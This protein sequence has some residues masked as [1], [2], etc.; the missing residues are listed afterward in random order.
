MNRERWE[1]VEQI[2]HEAIQQSPAD[3]AA[4]VAERCAGDDALLQE[5]ESLVAANAQ[6]GVFL[7]TPAMQVAASALSRAAITVGAGQMLGP[8]QLLMPVGAGG[9]GEVW[10]AHD[11]RVGRDVAIKFCKSF[12]DHFEREARSIG[13]LNHPNICGLYDVGP[14]YLV[15][16]LVEGPT[17]AD[18]IQQGPIPV[19][20]ALSIGRQIA[21]ALEA[22]HEKGRIHRDLKPGNIKISP[23]GVVKLLDFGL[24]KAV[25]FPAAEASQSA[26]VTLSAVRARAIMG[27]PAY[28]SPEHVRGSP[29]DKR[30]DIWAFGAVLY[31]MLTGKP[32]FA[33]ETA[34]QILEAVS[35]AEPDWSALPASTQARIRKLLRRCLERD[36]KQRLRDIGEA[37]I[38]IDEPEEEP[39]RPTLPV[40]PWL[41]AAALALGLAVAAVGWWHAAQ[42]V[43]LRPLMRV[44]VE[45]GSEIPLAKAGIQGAFAIAPDGSR[46]AFV[47]R[48][49][50]G[51]ERLATRSFNESRSTLLAGT[52]NAEGPFFSPDSNWMGF[53]AD[54]KLKKISVH[55]GAPVTLC[56]APGPRGASWGEDGNIIAAL[57][58]GRPGLTRIPSAGGPPTPVK[59]VNAPDEKTNRWP[60][61]LSGSHA[62]LFNAYQVGDNPDDAEIQV[63]SFKTGE[64]KTVEHGYF[65]R[66]IRSGH[67]VFLR[68]NTLFAAP[69]DLSRL[70]VAGP[71][72][73]V[74][75]DVSAPAFSGA[76]NLDFSQTGSF[77][78]LAGAAANRAIFWLDSA[79]N[80]RPLHAERGQ[81]YHPAFSPDGKRLAFTVA[82]GHGMDIWVQDFA[83]GDASRK[84]FLPGR[85]WWPLWTPNGKAIVFASTGGEVR[86]TLYMIRADG[87][88]EVERI[89]DENVRGVPRSFSPD[90][91]RLAFDAGA[92]V[93]EIWTATMKADSEHRRLG[94]AARFLDAATPAPDA[95][96]S[97]DGHWIAY[98]SAESGMANVFVRPFPG[99]GGTAQVSTG[100][101]RFPIWSRNGRELF[102]LGPDKR[103][104]VATYTT[105]GN[106]FSPGKSRVWSERQLGDW[107]V[108][109]MY[110]LAR[111]GKRFAIILDT[112]Q[113]GESKAATS[114][115][116]LVN[117]FDEL[118]RRVPLPRP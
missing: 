108:N 16:E 98:V 65:P 81:Y 21:E 18:R 69:F 78:Y 105:R 59:G 83:H 80:L 45:L 40:R 107:G 49:T 104:R 118:R 6:A 8:Y 13:A 60:Q 88:G 93:T 72:Q 52:E 63:F 62:V 84:S 99:P 51:I 30:T 91:I 33:G 96:F 42:P 116:V 113:T 75:D 2:Y 86:D 97:P 54:G 41:V 23:D 15:M 19:S 5:V 70:A 34:A 85:N 26:T 10:K 102:Y 35:T 25:E 36:R 11:S 12:T 28:M 9:M 76:A 89:S 103:I 27:T 22:A 100:G 29:V 79:G 17:L 68:Q 95:Q 31:E 110:D 112:D 48:D 53:F 111:D 92:T 117:F 7:D 3:R 20:E 106:S 32:V 43:P 1:Q 38:V 39:V 114:V 61:I 64:R 101:G 50:N 44:S 57:S 58:L 56:D 14:N 74:L 55:G 109:R 77:V 46:L 66:Y 71:A 4:Y 24:A 47:T 90:G 115:A 37:R 82:S 67:L 94:A 87:S 73:P